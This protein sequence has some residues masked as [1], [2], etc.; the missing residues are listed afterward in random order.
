MP[1]TCESCKEFFATLN[2]VSVAPENPESFSMKMEITEKLCSDRDR[3]GDSKKCF[4]LINEIRYNGQY[5]SS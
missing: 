5:G 4:Y 1:V 2:C 3:D